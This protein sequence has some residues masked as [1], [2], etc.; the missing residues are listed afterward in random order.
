MTGP[1]SPIPE[2][3][4]A[5]TRWGEMLAAWAI[6]D[7]LVAAAPSP[8]YFFDRDVFGAAADGA[9]SRTA[10]SPSD[11]IAR[12]ALPPGGSVLDVGCGAG[13]ASLRLAPAR[14]TAVDSH[15]GMLEAVAKRARSLGI[16]C[17]T[18]EG[19]WPDVA[20]RTP[21]ADVV[22]CHHVIYN[23]AGLAGFAQALGGHAR[24]RV[25]IELTA[26]HPMTWMAPYWLA[27]HGL[28]QPDHPTAS[29]ALDVLT[30]LGLTVRQERW[31]RPYQMLGEGGPHALDRLARRLCLPADRHHA[32]RRLL[33]EH[34][35]PKERDVV[36]L[37]W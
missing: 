33:D 27:H 7:D 13:A 14:L 9:L 34:P 18:M 30:A 5:D 4:R 29:D 25:V 19:A 15:P 20:A 12:E 3:D 22:V 37:W 6:P 21:V 17:E 36:T 2:V 35:P 28:T 10:D 23:V 8:P 26:V 11:G 24:H 16:E 31:S 1:H 32:L